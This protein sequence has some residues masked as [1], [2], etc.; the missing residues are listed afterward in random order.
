MN[1][2]RENKDALN[3]VVKIDIEKSDYADKVEKI[4]TDYKKSANIPGF[5]KGQVPMG[6]IKKQYGKAV[7]VD[8]VNKLLQESL[9]KYLN[10]EKLDVLGNPLPKAQDNIDWDADA[11]SFE[12]EIGL[13]PEFDIKLNGRKAITQYT[14]VADNKMVDDQIKNIQKQYGQLISKAEVSE[15]DEVTGVF[16]NDEAGIESTTTITL[17]KLKGKANLKK[18]VGAK[19]GDII[20]LKTKGLFKDSHDLMTYLKVD[21][22]TA[23]DLNVQ[24]TFTINEINE[25]GLADLDQELF[26]KLF[27]KDVVKTVT[28]L[29]EKIKADAEK[30]FVQQSDQK[31][32]NDVTEYLVENTK[33]DLPSEFLQKWLQTVGE[34]PMDEAQAKAE[35]EKSEKSMRYQLIESKLIVDNNLQVNFEELK[36]YAGEMIKGQM[37]QF[38]QLNPSDKEVEDIV[39]RVLS[40][41]DEVKRMSE[42]LTSQKLLTF[43]KE[44]AKLKSKELNYD[45]FVKEVYGK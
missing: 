45:A 15:G 26:D 22:D 41:Q 40:N 35:Y 36:A 13:S 4:L 5:R 42:Q 7:L 43:Y 30:Q 38:G 39:A 12:F 21:H 6:L 28:E 16:F 9:G 37:A 1:I 11:F 32:L 34:E 2:T 17:D 29:K 3:A 8:E 10:D 18:F 33:F 25:R 27:G 23:H 19:V 20:T 31:L 44:N 24:V 14:I